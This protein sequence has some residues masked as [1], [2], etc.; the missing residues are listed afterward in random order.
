MCRKSN[1]TIQFI[2]IID[3]LNA[4]IEAAKFDN[5]AIDFDTLTLMPKEDEQ[6]V[7]IR[8]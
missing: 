4:K 3:K 1:Q 8:R 7:V 6:F 5:F 2:F